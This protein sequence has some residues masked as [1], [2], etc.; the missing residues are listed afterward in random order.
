MK[1]VCCGSDINKSKLTHKDRVVLFCSRKCYIEYSSHNS[2]ECIFC[3]KVFQPKRFDQVYCSI[4]CSNKA[5][6][7][8]KRKPKVVKTQYKFS[9]ESNIPNGFGIGICGI[10]KITNKINGK[11]YIGK[12]NNIG[13]RLKQHRYCH[14]TSMPIHHAIEKYGIGNFTFEIIH[15]CDGASRSEIDLLERYYIK[16]Y[17]STN[18]KIGY[19]ATLGGDGGEMTPEARAKHK[20]SMNT[21]EVKERLSASMTRL[22]IKKPAVMMHRNTSNAI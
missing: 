7:H 8:S 10:Y 11:V 2:K 6:H 12:S 22:W 16:K 20:I 19:N 5:T 14:R 4:S 1:C 15:I 3:G 21:P 18:P 17:N 13:N 9:N